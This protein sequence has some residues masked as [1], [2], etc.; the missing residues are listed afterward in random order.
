MG[1]GKPTAL[2]TGSSSGIGLA[3]AKQLL[4]A[5]FHIGLLDIS[6]PQLEHPDVIPFLVDLRDRDGVRQ[7]V[8]A[9]AEELGKI[10]VLVNC[11]GWDRAMPFVDTDD[12]F[13]SKVIEINLLG[14]MAVTQAALPHL[15][16][17]G[18]IVNVASDAGRVGSSGEVV[19]SAAKGG[20][21]AF[22]KA[23]AREVAKRGIRVNAVAPGP[24]DTPFLTRFD[25]SGKL[26]EAMIRQTPLRKLATPEDV[27][28]AI[29][30][31]AS[32][33]AG[34]ITG[35]VLSVSGGLTMV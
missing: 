13:W 29:S 26:A 30:F 25:E 5:S 24:T 21:I 17:G 31:L 8:A 1:D 34:H 6:A 3:T 23:L 4:D 2:V 7:V 10:Q 19:Y 18:A 20:V 22:T 35:Q 15:E 32:P 16:D 33:D 9:A 11:A 14:P 27:A 28:R 12:A